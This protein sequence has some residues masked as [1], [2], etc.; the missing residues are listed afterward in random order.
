MDWLASLD[1]LGLEVAPEALVRLERLADELADRGFTLVTINTD[2]VPAQGMRFLQRY[3][4]HIPV[5]RMDPR[6]LQFH[7]PRTSLGDQ[8]FATFRDMCTRSPSR[9]NPYLQLFTMG[10]VV[11]PSALPPAR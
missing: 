4:I 11:T 10:R 8:F 1:E 2:Q 9:E 7:D 3:E 5:Y 6:S